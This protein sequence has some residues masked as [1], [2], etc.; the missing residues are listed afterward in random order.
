[1]LGSE[2]ITPLY[3]HNPNKRLFARCIRWLER[4]GYTFVSSD[5]LIEILYNGK[6][7]PKGA[8]WLSFDDGYKEWLEN[9]APVVRQRRVPVTFF[10]PSGIVENDGRLPWMHR[11]NGSGAELKGGRDTITLAELRR[12]A[13]YPEVTIGAHTVNHTVTANL[14]EEEARYEFGHCQRTLES[15]TGREVKCF[16]YPEGRFDGGEKRMLC[17]FGYRLA[18]VTTSDFITR[19]T[20]P[21]LAP[22]LCIGDDISFAEAVCNM[23]GVW[24][25]ALDSVKKIFATLKPRS[26]AGDASAPIKSFPKPTEEAKWN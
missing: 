9:V 2:V 6:P 22:R 21:Y 3:F 15:W 13:R 5:D 1:M 14:P 24:R 25:P 17:E 11:G 12:V 26:R 19:D 23:V 18:A 20:D 16:A 10:I 8:V 4:H 7:I